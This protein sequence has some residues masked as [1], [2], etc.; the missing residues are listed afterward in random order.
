MPVGRVG[1]VIL[2]PVVAGFFCCGTKE[3]FTLDEN[4]VTAR[5]VKIGTVSICMAR[6]GFGVSTQGT[7]LSH[8]LVKG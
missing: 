2:M 7:G 1:G 6:S 4:Q 5:A 3:G 8:R